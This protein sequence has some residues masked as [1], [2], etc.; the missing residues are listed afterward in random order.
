MRDASVYGGGCVFI[1]FKRM[2]TAAMQGAPLFNDFACFATYPIHTLAV[3]TV[4]ASGSS[5]FL[6]DHLP[7]SNSTTSAVLVDNT[8]LLAILDALDQQQ[9]LPRSSAAIK[10]TS[11]NSPPGVQAYINRM[12]GR[13]SYVCSRDGRRLASSLISHSFRRDAAQNANA[14]SKLSLSWILNRGEWV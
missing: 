13:W 9:I 12:I 14:D 3:A 7:R 8:P 4:M 6:L 1:E 5:E 10:P 2:K 11:T